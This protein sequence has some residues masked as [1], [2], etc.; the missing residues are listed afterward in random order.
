MKKCLLSL[1]ASLAL[2]TSAFTAESYSFGLTLPLRVDDF[3]EIASNLTVQGVSFNTNLIPMVT[4]SPGSN[5]H[6]KTLTLLSKPN[7]S[8]N[9]QISINVCDNGYIADRT[10][11]LPITP[12]TTLST[13]VNSTTIPTFTLIGS[14]NAVHLRWHASSNKFGYKINRYLTNYFSVDRYFTVGITSGTNFVDTNVVNGK[15]YWYSVS[16]VP[17][18]A[19]LISVDA[20]CTNIVFEF[21]VRPPLDLRPYPFGGLYFISRSNA[22]Y[23][24]FY[25]TNAIQPL[26][27]LKKE[28]NTPSNK[29]ITLDDGDGFYEKNLIYVREKE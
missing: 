2:V 25:K 20:L 16:W 6:W 5:P 15:T 22:I 28:V 19:Q 17:P 12:G 10:S 23:Q 29:L 7:T 14:N 24:V 4:I 27:L 9:A 8:G 13:N 1:L 18:N 11:L 26:W 3:E 21:R